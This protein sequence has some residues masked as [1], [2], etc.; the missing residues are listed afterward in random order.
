MTQLDFESAE[1]ESFFAP[2][3]CGT[4]GI[5]FRSLFRSRF[6]CELRLFFVAIAPWSARSFVPIAMTVIAPP[7]AAATSF[8]L[9]VATAAATFAPS[10]RRAGVRQH[11]LLRWLC[12]LIVHFRFDDDALHAA[13]EAALLEDDVVEQA[14]TLDA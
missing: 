8:A 1:S 3:T 7:S 10:G 6:D 2:F 14:I 13:E 9:H 4:R 12:R 11:M 5:R